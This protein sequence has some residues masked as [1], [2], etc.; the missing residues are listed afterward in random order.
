MNAPTYEEDMM[1][2]VDFLALHGLAVRKAAG[3]AAVADLLG[4]PEA[5]VAAA[6][7]AAV[8]GG[9]AAGAKG[10]FMV[11]PTGQAWLAEQYPV[12]YA[13]AREDGALNAA[14]ERFEKVNTEL[15]ALFTDWQTMPAG[16]QRVPNDHSDADY[17]RAIIDRL[18]D[19]HERAERVVG[20]CAEAQPRLTRYLERLELAYDKVLAGE[21]D[22]VSGVRIDSYHTVWFEL[23][24]DLLRMLGR[25]R[26]E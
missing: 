4:L 22:Y 24:E 3:P 23:H 7:D 13:D 18:G 5:D 10:T 12:L 17:D 21:I 6:L 9:M 14:Y 2:T 16:G 26:Q 19:L 1:T 20:R 11:A 8:A 25:T 15:L